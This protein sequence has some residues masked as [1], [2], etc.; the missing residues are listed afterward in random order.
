MFD[1][2]HESR[3]L[4]L[5]NPDIKRAMS[6]IFSF[7][8]SR[9]IKRK[10]KEIVWTLVSFLPFFHVNINFTWGLFCYYY[11]YYDYCLFPLNE[12][13]LTSHIGQG[14][15]VHSIRFLA[16]P[17]LH[18]GSCNRDYCLPYSYNFLVNEHSPVD[19]RDHI[20]GPD[21]H[22]THSLISVFAVCTILL[23]IYEELLISDN[24]E[25]H[26]S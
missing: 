15:A 2:D 5:G 22:L 24:I 4:R 11:Y 9:T 19:D 18:N 12:L 3:S 13:A 23:R 1:C 6:S 21:D 20:F 25:L 7:I 8:P 16:A 17:N 10:R 14:H 26:I